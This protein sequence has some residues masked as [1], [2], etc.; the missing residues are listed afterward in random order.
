MS[1][2]EFPGFPRDTLKFLYE[3]SQNNNKSWFDANKERYRENILAYAPAFVASL[4][5]RLQSDISPAIVY[6][7]R[8]NGAGSMM[9]IYRDV[10]FSRD[11]TPYKTNIAFVFWEGPRKKMENPSFGFQFGDW[12]AGL[13]GGLWG[14]PKGMI[15]IYRRAVD[16]D[17]LGAELEA[18]IE[19]VKAAGDYEISGDRYKRAPRGYDADHPRVELLKYKGLHASSPQF[20]I[21]II[22]TP[23]VIDTCAQHCK[24]MAPLQQWLAK[25]DQMG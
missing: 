25:I 23:E 18:A 17:R 2:T 9:R 16:D 1:N 19:A 4:G 21:E 15:D 12:G 14:F 6:D 11:K 22:T 8:T 20:D 24:N 13:Y 10:R 3:L 7:T 5:Q